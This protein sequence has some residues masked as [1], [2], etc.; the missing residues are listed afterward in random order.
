MLVYF[1]FFFFALECKLDLLCFQCH[2]HQGAKK[3]VKGTAPLSLHHT[4]LLLP[5]DGD[6][7]AI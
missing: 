2:L 3:I 1:F 6:Q 7:R 4:D 5:I